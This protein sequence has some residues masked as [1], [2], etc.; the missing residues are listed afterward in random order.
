MN[1][2]VFKGWRGLH[3]RLLL[4]A[5]TL[6]CLLPFRGKA[7]HIDDP[8]FVWAAQNIVHHPL[9]P[10]GFPVVWYDV[11]MPMSQ[12]TENPPAASYYMAAVGKAAG[13]SETALHLAFLLP[14]LVVMLG[15]YRLAQRF[16]RYPLL[17]GLATL[18]TPGFVVSS[19]TVM[20]DTMMLAFWI[21]GACIWL[22]GLDREQP[23]MLAA[24]GI[25]I[26]V[27]TLTKYFGAALIPLLLIY[28]LLLRRRVGAR[29]F[30]LLTPVLALAAYQYWTR[31]RYGAALFSEAAHYALDDD[32]PRLERAAGAVFALAFAGGCVL[33]ALTFIPVVW[34]RWKILAGA[35]LGGAAGFGYVVHWIPSPSAGGELGLNWVG[36]QLG[37]FVAGG[38]SLLGLALA[39]WRRRRDAD[40]AFL[41]L[42]VLGT[43]VFTAFLNWSVNARSLL[44]L[45]PAAG[46]LLAR[47]LE[48]ADVPHRRSQWVKVAVPLA[49]SGIVSMWVAAADFRLADA[50]RQAAMQ[51]HEQVAADPSPARFEGHWGFQYYMQLLGFRPVD[52]EAYPVREGDLIVIPQNSTNT[53]PLPV[54]LIES[55]TQLAFKVN[56]GVTTTSRELGAGFYTDFLGPLPYVFGSVPDEQYQVARFKNA[57]PIKRND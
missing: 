13:W 43:F 18:L 33:P 55:E 1:F 57:G 21:L 4:V 45:I 27:S 41:G 36:L 14:A 40:S 50:G 29:L 54:E 19:T 8:L 31:S 35:I 46:I 49:V 28:S 11:S 44:P 47:R 51:I 34:S 30:F 24:A 2:V 48:S 22:E 6:A 16:T 37:I 38:L 12:V 42:W 52:F 10:Y 17:A 9:D 7:F 56:V 32:T 53:E 3:S 25:L 20:C 39:D 23:A 15:T 26:A 5:L